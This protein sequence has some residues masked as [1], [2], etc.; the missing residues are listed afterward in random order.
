MA[1]SSGL[2]LVDGPKHYAKKAIELRCGF[3]WLRFLADEDGSELERI[4]R[5]LPEVI[6]LRPRRG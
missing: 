2:R 1:C 6:F 4:A 5:V 3:P